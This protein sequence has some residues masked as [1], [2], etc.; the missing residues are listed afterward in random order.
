M[1]KIQIP[2]CDFC[3]PVLIE[4][5]IPFGYGTA[6]RVFTDKDKL[7]RAL[8]ELSLLGVHIVCTGNN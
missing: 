1:E 6:Q 5:Y 4:W 7:V 2:P 3:H 8:S